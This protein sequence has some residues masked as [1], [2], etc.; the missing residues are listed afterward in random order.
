MRHVVNPAPVKGPG[1]PNPTNS[2]RNKSF[3]EQNNQPK[4]QNNRKRKAE[5]SEY[6]IL[7]LKNQKLNVN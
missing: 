3:V 6:M 2:Q 5:N 1:R 7:R 4:I